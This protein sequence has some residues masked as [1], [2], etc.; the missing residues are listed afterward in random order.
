LTIQAFEGIKIAQR[1]AEVNRPVMRLFNE[2]W[3]SHEEDEDYLD[4]LNRVQ[5]ITQE[6]VD[7]IKEGKL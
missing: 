2:R 5:I 7:L 4:A 6:V 1:A 3:N